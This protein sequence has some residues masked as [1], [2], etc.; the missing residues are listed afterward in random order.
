MSAPLRSRGFRDETGAGGRRD[1]PEEVAVALSY[2]GTTQAVMMATPADLEDFARGFTLTEGLAEP[3]EIEEIA[4]Q[5]AAGGI[6]LQ[7][8]LLP[9]AAARLAARRRGRAGPVGCGLCGIESIA[10]ALRP[11]APVPPSGLRLAAGEV[12]AAMAA[13][14][15]AQPLHRAT[16]AV[17]AAG[18]WVPGRGLVMAREDVGRHNA[19][20]K[21]AGA[22]AAAGVA[23]GTGAL[24]LTSRLSLDLV[25]KAAVLG[26]PAVIAA[27]A[28]TA[29][30][31]DCAE[32]AGITVAAQ[33]RAGRFALYA[34]PGRVEEAAGAAR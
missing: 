32:A 5:A 30:A 21:L 34:H 2:D 13:L 18:L 31:V 24:V 7:I 19:L 12:A 20:D 15:A 28:P 11:V 33:A 25:Q 23:A 9:G 17:H 22:M 6:D 8:R 14:A 1:L 27:A 29:A 16:A 4:V 26:V 10:E 3:A